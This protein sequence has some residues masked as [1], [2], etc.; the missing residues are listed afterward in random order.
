MVGVSGLVQKLDINSWLIYSK[1]LSAKNISKLIVKE[2]ST[3]KADLLTGEQI[4]E[5]ERDWD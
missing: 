1:R 2:T 5:N 4:G 3:C